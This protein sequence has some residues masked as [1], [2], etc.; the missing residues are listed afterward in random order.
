MT[1]YW[2]RA[3]APYR[4]VIEAARSRIPEPIWRRVETVRFLCGVDPIWAGFEADTSNGIDERSYRDTWHV[5]WQPCHQANLPADQRQTTI[6]IPNL[7]HDAY[8][9]LSMIHEIGH[10]LDEVDGFQWAAPA[11]D[12]HADHNRYEAFACAFTAWLAPE[13]GAMYSDYRPAVAMG[14]HSTRRHWEEMLDG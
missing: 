1:D 8:S 9:V 2:Y 14:D 6:I 12:A 13:Y 7:D 4:A 3:P 5:S 10:V 11:I